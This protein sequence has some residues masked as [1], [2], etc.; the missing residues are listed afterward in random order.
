MAT[1]GS[2]NVTANKSPKYRLVLFVTT[3]V[4]A[5]G[6]SGQGENFSDSEDQQPPSVERSVGFDGDI[7][8]LGVIANLTGPGASLDRARLTGVAA[9]W[10]DVNA[11]GGVGGRYAVELKIIDHLGN[12]ELAE[13]FT[14]GL[15]DE[16]VS[17]AFVN[18][19]AV[20][21][22]HPFLVEG[23]VLG[24]VATSTLDWESDSRFLTHSP[25]IEAVVLALFESTPLAKWCVITDGSPL[26]VGLRRFASQAAQIAKAQTV[27]L[28]GI[29][30]DLT[31]AVSAAAC[32]HIL[33]EVSEESQGN[34]VSSLPPNRIV[35]RLAGITDSTIERSDLT[36]SYLDSGPSWDVDSADGMRPFLAAL[37]RHAPDARADTRIRDGYVS[38][39]RLHQ[40]LE[41]AVK[42][43]DLRRS[44]LFEAGQTHPQVQMFGLAE[45]IDMSLEEP[46][47]PRNINVQIR[48]SDDDGAD[49]RGWRLERTLRAQNVSALA[50]ETA[51]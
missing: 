21:A 35:Y 31:S 51:N 36:F 4:L 45:E 14:P 28:I 32:D 27:T 13:E 41:A 38:Q 26:G 29:N 6:C 20:G 22:V 37:L 23:Q 44:S 42:S 9:Y 40:L 17:L 11:S 18:E 25:P 10:S 33:A 2:S 48:V 50:I 1:A 30:E 43:G 7:I 49:A 46:P 16:I 12:P 47:L 15:L 34:F 3:L 8:R 24:V 19:T 5:C 39:I